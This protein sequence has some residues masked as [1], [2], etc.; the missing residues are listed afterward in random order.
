MYAGSHQRVFINTSGQMGIGQNFTPSRHLDIK[1]STGANR[2][3]NIR[4]TGT[5]GAFVAFLDANT[6]DDSK[7]RIGSIGGNNI[8]IRG[9]SHSFQDGGGNNK[10]TISSGGNF[11]FYNSTAAWNT[12]QRANTG[13]YIGIRIQETDTTQRMQLGVAGTTNHIA[14]GSAQHDVVLKS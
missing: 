12:L 10:L 5:S 1:D 11:T 4:G 6:T 3:V 7:C 9:D 8:G 13:H 14:N 2:I